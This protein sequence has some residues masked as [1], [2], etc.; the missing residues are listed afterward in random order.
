[1]RIRTR[2]V[3]DRGRFT[4]RMVNK[5][6]LRDVRSLRLQAPINGSATII[7]CHRDGGMSPESG[8][9]EF[10]CVVGCNTAGPLPA[11]S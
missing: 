11:K 1:M 2:T 5:A 9:M 8:L 7:G 6:S 4:H 10:A 3:N